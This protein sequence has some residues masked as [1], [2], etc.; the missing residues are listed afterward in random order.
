MIKLDLDY[1]S[2]NIQWFLLRICHTPIVIRGHIL[3]SRHFSNMVTMKHNQ[4][5]CRWHVQLLLLEQ[6][7]A[8]RWHPVAPSKAINIFH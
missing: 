8:Q 4:K 7:L 5:K 3:T 6:I 1:L 2:K